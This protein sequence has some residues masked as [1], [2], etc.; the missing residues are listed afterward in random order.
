MISSYLS[1][2]V[3][4]LST[5]KSICFIPLKSIVSIEKTGV[6]LLFCSRSFF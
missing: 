5:S 3:L 6:S 4:S 1:I 2:I